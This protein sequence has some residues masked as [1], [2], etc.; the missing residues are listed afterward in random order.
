[1]VAAPVFALLLGAMMCIYA[2][3]AMA[4]YLRSF[5]REPFLPVYVSSAVLSI[6]LALLTT[7]HWGT[8][9]AAGSYALSSATVGLLFAIWR[10]VQFRSKLA[11]TGIPGP[12]PNESSI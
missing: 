6:L 3:Q 10:F 2:I 12:L 11:R 4:I 1:M 5:K 8:L 7:K 9:G